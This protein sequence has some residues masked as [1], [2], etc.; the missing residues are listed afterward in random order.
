VTFIESTRL[1]LLV[2]G[3]LR[4]ETDLLVDPNFTGPDIYLSAEPGE[5]ATWN[6][7]VLQEVTGTKSVEA[8][9]EGPYTYGGEGR[10]GSSSLS[11]EIEFVNPEVN[12]FDTWLT[13]SGKGLDVSIVVMNGNAYTGD[14]RVAIEKAGARRSRPLRPWRVATA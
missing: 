7:K 14:L 11:R 5:T 1:K 10:T 13:K 4:T 12:G 6:V 2:D 9:V 3:E 8:A